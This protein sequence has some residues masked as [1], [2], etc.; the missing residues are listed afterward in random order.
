MSYL[1]DRRGIGRRSLNIS[2]QVCRVNA[3]HPPPVSEVVVPLKKS[4]EGIP[5]CH[6]LLLEELGV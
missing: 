2:V 6:D 4:D 5:H 3:F 1:F